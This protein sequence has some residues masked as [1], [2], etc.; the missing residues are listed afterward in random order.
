MNGTA[1][2]VLLQFDPELRFFLRKE[3]RGGTVTRVLKE[4]TSIKDVIEAC[5]V[6]HPEVNRII[7]GGRAVSFEHQVETSAEVF[8]SSIFDAFGASGDSLQLR[9]VG[10]FVADGHLG[11]LARDL[12]LLG[13][14]VAYDSNADDKALALQSATEERALL[15]RDRR[16]LMHKAIRHGYCLRSTNPD[17]QVIEVARRFDLA[18]LE[19]PFTRC[20]RCNG[21]LERVAKAAVLDELEPLTRIYYEEFRRCAGCGRIYWPGSHFGNLEARI[22]KIRSRFN[23]ESAIDIRK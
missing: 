23:R 2:P 6:P 13:L 11:K 18:E 15:T 14:D 21:L 8:V 3:E 10:R 1:F 19:A 22:E 7:I 20:L 16:L 17:E 4:K 5:G 12:R 9:H